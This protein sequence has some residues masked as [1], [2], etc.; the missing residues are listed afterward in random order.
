MVFAFLQESLEKVINVAE[1]I[2]GQD[3][4][5]DGDVGVAGKGSDRASSGNGA[6]ADPQR[7][8]AFLDQSMEQV[9]NVAE[10]VTGQDIDRDGDV[11]VA[12]KRSGR[13]NSG[14][15]KAAPPATSFL[16]KA[17]NVAEGITGLDLDRDGDVG[18]SGNVD[19]GAGAPGTAEPEPMEPEEPD[20]RQ[21]LGPHPALTEADAEAHAA[22]MALVGETQERLRNG[23]AECSARVLEREQRILS[24]QQ[25]SRER[26]LLLEQQTGDAKE[27]LSILSKEAMR[28]EVEKS[29]E[30]T[31]ER[32]R[33]DAHTASLQKTHDQTR[34]LQEDLMAK[35]EN[36]VVGREA[37][38]GALEGLQEERFDMHDWFYM[39]AAR[40]TTSLSHD[41]VSDRPFGVVGPPTR[42]VE[43]GSGGPRLRLAGKA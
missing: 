8:T 32:K 14:G 22:M 17:I 27:M 2:A 3:L 41:D 24:K 34:R 7:L 16:E 42:G 31:A 30:V 10:N 11:G 36:F 25:A 38:Q 6:K 12:G 28:L 43:R 19:Q 9:I 21:A 5:R 20:T 35:R 13:S 33:L 4:D 26:M 29:S 23:L 18:V 37:L 1:G 39:P 15:D 40:L